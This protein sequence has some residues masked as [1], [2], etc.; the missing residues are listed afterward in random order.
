MKL[1]VLGG[2]VFLGRHTVA[3]AL[4]RGWEVTTFNR[5]VTSAD[6][7]GVRVVRGD[8]TE[9]RDL[10]RLAEQGPWD[11]V[12]DVCG[13][14]PRYVGA[15][16]RALSAQAG[17][18]VFISSVSAFPGWPAEA[19]DEDS[20]RFACSPDAG[21]E[22]GD[23]GTLK[24]GC[25]RAVERDFPGRVLIINPGLIIGPHENVGRVPYWLRRAARGGDMLAPGPRDRPL[26]LVDARDIAAFTLDSLERERTG[27][28]I[29]SG[30][31]GNCTWGELVDTCVELTGSLARP[32]WVDD[33]FLLG[34]EVAVW[35]GLPLWMPDRPEFAAVWAPDSSRA[36]AAGMSCR[37]VVESLRDT[38]AWLSGDDVPEVLPRYRGGL[39]DNGME[40]QRERDVIAA[41]FDR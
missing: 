37:P 12:V 25:E 26:Q 30:V 4:A 3:A 8:R 19:V 9:P 16:A 23:Y 39:P 11:A 27:R 38:W 41:W 6:V 7:P 36:L 29:T 21:P 31:R 33:D 40:P 15:A 1:L 10:A 34:H 24:S 13:F 18:Y 28:Y 32:V 22:D 14:V 2:S 20:P 17:S 5:G 35:S